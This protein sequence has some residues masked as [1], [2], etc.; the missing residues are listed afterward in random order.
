MDARKRIDLKLPKLILNEV[1]KICFKKAITRTNYLET[2]IRADLKKRGIIIEEYKKIDCGTFE[3]W[4]WEEKPRIY[5]K[6]NKFH[7]TIDN[8]N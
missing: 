4:G 3:E 8:V 7:Q 5:K 1:E 6:E 2:L